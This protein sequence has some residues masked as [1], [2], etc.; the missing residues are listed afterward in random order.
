MLSQ[1]ELDE[2]VFNIVIL[3]L[4]LLFWEKQMAKLPVEEN[5]W[6]QE[7]LLPLHAFRW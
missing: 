4:F 5:Y 7:G 2:D 3:F 1:V 6:N